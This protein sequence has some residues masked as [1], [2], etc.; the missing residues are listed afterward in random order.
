M[1]C[2]AQGNKAEIGTLVASVP[3]R[4]RWAG[5]PTQAQDASGCGFL[6]TPAPCLPRSQALEWCA[7]VS[8]LGWNEAPAQ[9]QAMVPSL[10]KAYE[11]AERGDKTPPQRWPGHRS[12]Q[13]P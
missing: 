6:W 13:W 8:L 5:K 11:E 2:L 1:L 10:L 3:G 9:L 12:P 4:G 7:L